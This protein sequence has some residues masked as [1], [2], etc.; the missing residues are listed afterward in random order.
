MIESLGRE[1]VIQAFGNVLE[2]SSKNAK[3]ATGDIEL[4]LT[5]LKILHKSETP[6]FT[7]EDES[8]GGDEIRMKYRYPRSSP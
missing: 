6:P 1:F 4:Q 8:D 7:I 2:R 3:M 5:D